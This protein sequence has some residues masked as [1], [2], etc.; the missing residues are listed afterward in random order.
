V[1]RRNNF[2]LRI[3]SRRVVAYFPKVSFR[4]AQQRAAAPAGRGSF[5]VKDLEAAWL[6][7]LA[8]A[9][10]NVYLPGKGAGDFSPA[11]SKNFP[12][13]EGG[14]GSPAA[15]LLYRRQTELEGPRNI[16]QSARGRTLT[17]S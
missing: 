13:V 12:A 5:E 1:R 6:R 8:L 14:A 10:L 4:N 11:H 2:T 9:K 17:V 3:T 15:R 16:G 7:P